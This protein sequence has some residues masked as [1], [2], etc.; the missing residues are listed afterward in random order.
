MRFHEFY[1]EFTGRNSSFQT[2]PVF[3]HN[4]PFILFF[5]LIRTVR[6]KPQAQEHSGII[7]KTIAL[8]FMKT[9]IHYFFVQIQIQLLNEII[10]SQCCDNTN[11]GQVHKA[12]NN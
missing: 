4:K 6:S 9:I 5:N 8:G 12:K 1:S 2:A 10:I 11:V 3:L 7:T